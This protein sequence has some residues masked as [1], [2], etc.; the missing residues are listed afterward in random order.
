MGAAQLQVPVPVTTDTAYLA[1]LIA[2]DKL[3]PV[4]GAFDLGLG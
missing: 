3:R 4:S 2:A 1:S